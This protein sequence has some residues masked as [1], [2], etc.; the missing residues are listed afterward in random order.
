MARRRIHGAGSSSSTMA[1]RS[2]VPASQERTGRDA[3][4]GIGK[5]EAAPARV[6]G[7]RDYGATLR[8]RGSVSSG[9]PPEQ[10]VT[11]VLPL[12]ERERE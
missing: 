6:H 11:L 3:T 5:L 8:A 12:R 7:E 2:S 1:S 10:G 9:A 4:E